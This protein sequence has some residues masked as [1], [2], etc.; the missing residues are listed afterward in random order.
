MLISFGAILGKCSLS[1]LWCL[2]TLEVIF[3]GLN[4]AICTGELG[5]VDI[6]GSMYVHA[7]G[8]YFGIAAS[9]FFD[10]NK[11]IKDKE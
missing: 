8:A 5:A 1:Q 2:A 10:P 7:F 11:A 3:W 6:G 9:Y 4:E